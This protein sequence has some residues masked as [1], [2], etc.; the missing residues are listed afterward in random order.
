VPYCNQCGSL[1]ESGQL[2]CPQC[3]KATDGSLAGLGPMP[4]PADAT[5]ATTTPLAGYGWRVLGYLIDSIILGVVFSYPLR[6]LHVNVYATAVT[7]A[8]VTFLYGTLFLSF[9]SGQ[10]PGMRVVRVRV[11]NAV[12]SATV[13]RL[14]AGRRTALYCALSLIGNLYHY[15][16]YAH[17]TAHQRMVESHHALASLAL[18]IPV[19]VD[20][21]WPLWDKRKQTLTDKFAGTVVV[22]PTAS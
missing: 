4:S 19:L 21:L 5:L 11:V 17:P 2:T 9:M 18:T 12:S 13:T 7:I 16:K 1:V 8:V 15:T 22:R 6:A 3:G 20:L 14:A 10:T